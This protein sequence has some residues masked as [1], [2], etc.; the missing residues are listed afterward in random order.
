MNNFKYKLASA[1]FAFQ[2]AWRVNKKVF[3]AWLAASVILSVLPA[4]VL[5]LNRNVISTLS[6]F[7]A[8]GQGQFSDIAGSIF[9]LG[10]F[11]AVNGLSNR[12]NYDLIYMMM[13]DTYYYGMGEQFM[14]KRQKVSREYLLNKAVRDEMQ[15]TS[16][17]YSTLNSFMT[18]LVAF[19]GK[20]V[21]AVSLLT[22]AASV[23]RTIFGIALA[24]IAAAAAYN[25]YAENKS[26]TKYEIYDRALHRAQY[27]QR[28]PKNPGLAKEVRIYESGEDILRQWREAHKTVEDY[29]KKR[30]GRHAKQP[31]VSGL[32]FY[33]AM[34]GIL[35]YSIFVVANGE[36]RA[37][38]FLMV[39]SL[40]GSLSGAISGMVGGIGSI[41]WSLFEL[42][43]QRRLLFSAP[44]RLDNPNPH[45]L[46][47]TGDIVYEFKNVTFG[48]DPEKPVLKDVSF[49][50]HKGENVALVGYN[51]SGK[52]TLT[53]LMLD[54][55]RPQS[56]EVCF[57]GRPISEYKYDDIKK[58]IGVFFQNCFIFHS[59]LRDNVGYGCVEEIQNEE[60]IRE[61]IRAGGAEKVVSRLHSDID[62][63]LRR[64]I[65]PD[66]VSLSGGETQRVCIARTHMSQ[67]PI[68]IFDEPAAALDP[69]AEM[70]QFM[71][72]KKKIEGRTSVLIS[73]RVGFARLA[74]RILVMDNGRLVEDGTHEELMQKDGVYASFFR[75]QAKWYTDGEGETV[76]G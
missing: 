23:S 55:Y 61:A 30:S 25:M 48:Y 15:S 46:D 10:L 75:E 22:I 76:N 44:E 31:F 41:S 66:G 32:L 13:Y 51:G 37:D 16:M 26:Q 14:N 12:V 17:K 5:V 47:T 36:M 20:L 39:Y 19:I 70:E 3:L 27:Y 49:K 34:A 54:S 57:Y 4:V 2:T 1:R 18:G 72:I 53:N 68:M 58:Q 8:T 52:T 43:R 62:T 64:D 33:L 67:A 71:E 11:I 35:L 56:G 63:W 73:H 69:I 45:A 21:S 59:S 7:I 24:Y 50:I 60:R 65:R 38:V 42:G 6:D 28:M 29:D 74:D 9:L 40:A